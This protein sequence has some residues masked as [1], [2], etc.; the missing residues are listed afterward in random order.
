[1][2]AISNC[3]IPYDMDLTVGM[4][5]ADFRFGMAT[6]AY[7]VPRI[8]ETSDLPISMVHLLAKILSFDGIVL[9][10]TWQHVITLSPL[11][12]AYV[13]LAVSQFVDSLFLGIVDIIFFLFRQ[14]WSSIDVHKQ[15]FLIPF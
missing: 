8:I 11:S 14:E 6:S 3:T 13:S 4:F 5:P 7:Q 9:T 2:Q 10:N 15:F 1:M 12:L